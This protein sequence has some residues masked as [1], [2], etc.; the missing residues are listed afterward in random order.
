MACLLSPRNTVDQNPFSVVVPS[1]L[2]PTGFPSHDLRAREPVHTA[3]PGGL[4]PLTEQKVC[5]CLHKVTCAMTGQLS[6][7]SRPSKMESK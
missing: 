2:I 5:S 3:E 1:E 4:Q 7:G 6:M